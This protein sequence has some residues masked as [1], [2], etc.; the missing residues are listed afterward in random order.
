M[1]LRSGEGHRG[2]PRGRSKVKRGSETKFSLNTREVDILKLT[3][4][5]L[6]RLLPQFMREDATTRAFVYAIEKQL[7]KI[8]ADIEY[9]K[10]YSRIDTMSDEWL[11]ELA[12]QFN[13]PEYN[14]AYDISIKR[15][16]IKNAMVT[17]HQ[18]GTVGAVEKAVQ[19]IFGIANL[20]EWFD[21]GGL[22]YHFK[23]R[24]SNP[25]ASDEMLAD[26]ER[27]IKETQNIRSYLE[28]VVVE[29]MQSMSLYFA[30]KVII[31]DEVSL[32]T[33]NI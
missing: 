7:N 28:E 19:D 27:V 17:H 2:R 29:L 8:S 14:A 22:P 30:A 26:L 4:I 11:N 31:L 15:S 9:A 13:I 6:S 24:T 32:K 10:I 16:L 12:W 25:N 33:I 23:V 3:E 18:R 1:L 21:Y 20:E 5:E